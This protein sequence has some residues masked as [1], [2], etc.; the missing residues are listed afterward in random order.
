MDEADSILI[1]EARTPLI[2]GSLGDRAIEKIVA[3]YRCASEMVPRF[4]EDE[5]YEYDH[6]DKKVELTG[7]GRQMV[8]TLPK[9]E[10][11]ATMGLIDLYQYIERA[12]KVARDYLLDRQYVVK[13]GEIV[14]VD[15]NTGRLA[16]GR[17]W[18][19][20]IH[21]AIEA[22]EKIEVS[23]PTGQAARITVQDLFLRYKHLAGMTASCPTAGPRHLTS[24]SALPHQ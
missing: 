18:R 3:T 1:D 10:L 23:V 19:D 4:I 7:E 20:G 13:D 14:I 6:D 22:K 15:E 12:I 24:T 11:L 9:P 5:H 17:K 21:Q 8:R 2:I 16:E